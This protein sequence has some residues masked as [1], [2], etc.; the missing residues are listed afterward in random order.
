MIYHV[1]KE[2]PLFEE[3]DICK[4][5][6]VEES[7]EM[8]KHFENHIIQFDTETTGTDAHIDKCLLAQFGNMDKSIQITVD[9]TTIDLTLYKEVIET[10]F[11]IGQNLKFDCQVIFNYGI[12]IHNCWDTMIVEQLLYLGFPHFMIGASEDIIMEYCTVVRDC[13]NWDDMD[14]KG[15]KAYLR[16]KCPDVADFIEN[17]SGVS[18]KALCYR[19]LKYEMSKE[20]RGQIN[21]KGPNDLDVIV[22]G[23]GDVTYLYDIMKAQ[24]EIVKKKGLLLASKVECLFTPVCAYYEYS[25]VHMNVPLWTSKMEHDTA[26]MNTALEALNKFVV[27]Q[28]DSRFIHIN[29]QGDLFGMDLDNPTSGFDSEPKCTINWNSPKQVIPFLTLLGFN[30]KG[31]DKKTKE[32][33]DSLDASV[34]APQRHVN[35]EFYDIYLAYSEAKKVCSTYGQNYLNAINP[36]TNRLHTTFRAIGTD[37]GR[38]ACGSQQQN[39]SL[40]KLKGLPC[41]SKSAPKDTTLKCAY[42][43]MQNLPADEI[44]RASFC[45]EPGNAWISV[46]YCGEESVL[47]ADFSQ[48]TAMMNVFLTGEDMH[49]TVAY[50]LYPD[51]I[52]RDTSIKDIKKLYKHLRQEAKGPE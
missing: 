8:L 2:R 50:M 27:D 19:Y 13:S 16:A 46:D 20:V 32:E 30:C 18:L 40:A 31:I 49:S 5:I 41:S 51:Q 33:K 36:N 42:P 52:P 11:I 4:Y 15:H 43:Q 24:L 47:M 14:A 17:H 1:S 38:L 29:L 45:A 28:G 35:S 12:I 48:D 23:A 7:L 9:C 26:K 10:S 3:P 21:Y 25:G 6:T 39:I 22:Y 44:T 37:T 34:L